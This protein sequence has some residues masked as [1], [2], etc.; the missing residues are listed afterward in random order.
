[1]ISLTL[2]LFM[3]SVLAPSMPNGAS[4]VLFSINIYANIFDRENPI[5]IYR[6]KII[7]MNQ[8]I[9]VIITINTTYLSKWCSTIP[10]NYIFPV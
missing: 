5:E 6:Y 1:M 2:E 9:M 8:T 4:S 10:N 7:G 3:Y